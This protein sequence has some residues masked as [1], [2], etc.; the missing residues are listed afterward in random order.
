LFETLRFAAALTKS[1]SGPER[2]R[3]EKEILAENKSPLDTCF[4]DAD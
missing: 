2:E 1:V 3:Q 4:G